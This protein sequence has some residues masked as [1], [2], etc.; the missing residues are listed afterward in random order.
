[1]PNTDNPHNTRG[2]TK[3]PATDSHDKQ[4]PPKRPNHGNPLIHPSNGQTSPQTLQEDDVVRATPTPDTA[5]TPHQLLTLINDA[6]DRIQILSNKVDAKFEQQGEKL[7]QI[8]D[9]LNGQRDQDG[10]N[11]PF[12]TRG[13]APLSPLQFVKLAFPWVSESLLRDI[14]ELKMDVKDLPKLLPTR[15]R[16][17]SRVATSGIT[18]TSILLDTSNASAKVIE[19]DT[20][21]YDK[22][23]TD[24]QV[25]LSILNVYAAIRGL[26]EYADDVKIVLAINTYASLL[27]N[28]D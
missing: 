25:L 8:L 1:M 23:I 6:D 13:N 18:G 15:H 11:V 28:W 19:P 4:P 2:T 3:R 20:P 7:Q 17:K 5:P 16:S 21:T 9:H 22:E 10:S 14:I 12:S 26:W 27:T 24:M